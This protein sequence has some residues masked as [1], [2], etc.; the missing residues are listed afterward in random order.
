MTNTPHSLKMGVF[1][2]LVEL[3]EPYCLVDARDCLGMNLAWMIQF[4]PEM[5]EN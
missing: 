1:I 4:P 2:Q 3:A 5:V